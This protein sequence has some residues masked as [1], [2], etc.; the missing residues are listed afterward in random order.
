MQCP[1]KEGCLLNRSLPQNRWDLVVQPRQNLSELAQITVPIL[2]S[3]VRH[4]KQ[5]TA[6]QRTG[7]SNQG[8]FW[9]FCTF[10]RSVLPASNINRTLDMRTPIL[11]SE[12]VPPPTLYRLVKVSASQFVFLLFVRG[13]DLVASSSCLK[14][15]FSMRFNFRFKFWYVQPTH[16]QHD[17]CLWRVD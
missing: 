16:R 8:F 11:N 6:R 15:E 2:S 10:L 4:D 17:T 9:V 13:S 3:P 7:R 5:I 12:T 1:T 14:N